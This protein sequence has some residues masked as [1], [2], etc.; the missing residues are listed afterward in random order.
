[1]VAGDFT[2]SPASF[3]F[4][5]NKKVSEENCKLAKI[6]S[7]EFLACSYCSSFIKYKTPYIIKDRGVILVILQIDSI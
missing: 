7:N 4:F 5:L 1:M 2:S 6:V 3:F